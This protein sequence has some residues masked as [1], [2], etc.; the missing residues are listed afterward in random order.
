L[1]AGVPL[2]G[3]DIATRLSLLYGAMFLIGGIQAPFLPVWLRDRGLNI[4]EIG[5]ILAA[6]RLLQFVALPLLTR[7]ADRR[8]EIVRML[9]ISAILMALIY[10]ALIV[11]ASFVAI[12]ALVGLLF[13]AQIGAMPLI[14][15]LT[16]A[17]YRPHDSRRRGATND[18]SNAGSAPFDYGRIRKWGSVAFIAGN[19]LAGVFLSLTSVSAINVVLAWSAVLAAAVAVYAAPLDALTQPRPSEPVEPVGRRRPELLLLVIV[20]AAIIQA[21]HVLVLSFGA[22]HW[23]RAGYSN[24]F[25]G[26]AWAIGVV[27]ETL[28]FAFIGRA[29]TASDRAPGL[30]ILGASVALVRWIVMAFDPGPIVLSLAQAGHGLSFAATHVG[31]MLLISQLAPAHMRGRA[32]GWMVAANAGLSA[33]LVALCGPLYG[34]LREH[35]YFVM[36]GFALT[37]LALSLLIRARRAA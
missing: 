12:L 15:V 2:Q 27:S 35:A 19:L 24:A 37:G 4:D 29:R 13:C 14:D 10:S 3:R 34:S 9:L 1:S 22:I 17:I 18:S 26:F 21:S 25:I 33:I 28:F 32:Q 8:G 30:M 20:A 36:A 16:F 23:A 6:P 5:L 11:T 7:W 31:T